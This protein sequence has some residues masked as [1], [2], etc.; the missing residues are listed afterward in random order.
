M[1]KISD[2]CRRSSA[3]KVIPVIA[4]AAILAGALVLAG[5]AFS[6][7]VPKA[8][9][10]GL[11]RMSVST[12]MSF[13]LAGVSLLATTGIWGRDTPRTRIIAWV[14]LSVVFGAALI[15]FSQ[16]IFPWD[17]NLFPGWS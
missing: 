1:P 17:A 12:A 3:Q 5:W 13:I 8:L 14:A 15:R 2:N 6:V 7:E 11:P 4:F 10:P 16:T 9:V